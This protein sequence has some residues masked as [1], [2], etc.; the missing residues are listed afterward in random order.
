M[1]STN[2]FG[3][4]YILRQNR[5]VDGKYPV[6]VRITVNKSRCE[7]ALKSYLFKEDWNIAKG[8]A[9]PK[10]PELKELNS[11]LEEVRSKIVTHYQRLALENTAVTAEAVKNAYLGISDKPAAEIMTLCKLVDMHNDLMK[12]VLK[13]GT[14][15]NYY[16][17]AIYLRKFLAKKSPTGD[18]RLEDLNY[19]FITAFEFYIRNNP[20]KSGDPCTNNGTMKHLER[21]KKMV[22]WAAN[23][24]WVEKNPFTAYKIKFKRHEM[25]FL[26]KDELTRIES[27]ELTDP[28]LGR[29]RDLFVFS[30]Y[31]GLA[32]ID[33]VS[34]HP[35][36]IL[37]AVDG[38]KW[39]KTSRKKTDIP[40]NVPLLSLPFPLWI[41]SGL[42]K[43][44]PNGKPCSPGSA[45]RK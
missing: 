14:L 15:K 7:L 27:R 17:T 24:E 41:N 36:N 19:A 35:G 13:R 10:N 2:T 33:L 45:T 37:S 21:L 26:D 11:Y 6:Y 4:H 44:P 23:N 42:R 32:Y 3:V 20:L 31:T 30:C 22:T 29:V 12:S 39:I 40:V 8:A 16:S 25:E 18:I 9:K 28:M 38:M 5:P 34:L 1:K 43:T